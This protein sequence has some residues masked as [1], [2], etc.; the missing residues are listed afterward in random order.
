MLETLAVKV[1]GDMGHTARLNIIRDRFVAGHDSCA[2]R[3]HLDSVPP[4]TPIRDIVDRCR[5]W[6]SHADTEAR[7]FNKPGPESVLLIYTVDEPGAGWMTGWWHCDHPTGG[8][9]PVGSFAKTVAS[10]LVGAG[11]T[12]QTDTHL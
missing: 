5:V 2:L 9:G 3:R 1:I 6:E 4:D 8:I 7:R 10:N 12:P 11:V